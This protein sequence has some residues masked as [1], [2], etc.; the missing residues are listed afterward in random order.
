MSASNSLQHI[1][2]FI[3][4]RLSSNESYFETKN[5]YN[6]IIERDSGQTVAAFIE[7]KGI[8]AREKDTVEHL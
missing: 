6:I 5:G 8:F 2:M 7:G 3:S 4:P 1:N